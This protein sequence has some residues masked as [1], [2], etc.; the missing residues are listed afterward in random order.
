[1][2]RSVIFSLPLLVASAVASPTW[3][4]WHGQGRNACL[5]NSTVQNIIESYTYLLQSPQGDD[6][7]ATANALLSDSF[8]VS[9]DSINTLVNANGGM[10]PVRSRCRLIRPSSV[11]FTNSLLARCQRLPKQE[12]LHCWSSTNACNPIG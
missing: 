6:F 12:S 5:S 1:M 10:V 3:G 8:F 7:N 2:L 4:Q 9:S 11:L